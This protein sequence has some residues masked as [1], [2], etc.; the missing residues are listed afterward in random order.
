[1]R[2]VF[3]VFLLSVLFAAGAGASTVFDLHNLGSLGQVKQLTADGITLTLQSNGAGNL[4]SLATTFGIDGSGANDLAE[5]L[6]G[7]NGT[8]ETLSFFFSP[9]VVVDSIDI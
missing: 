1:M 7:G 9:S 8:A 3:V 4:S 6:D 5:L 2:R